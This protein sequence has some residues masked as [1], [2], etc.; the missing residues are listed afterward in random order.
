MNA[1]IT[2]YGAMP[3]P[4]TA[5]ATP[6]RTTDMSQA[7]STSFLMLQCVVPKTLEAGLLEM[8]RRLQSP[9]D[10]ARPETVE[11]LTEARGRRIF[12]SRHSHMVATVVLEVEV[13][14]SA[15]RENDFGQ[16]ALDAL[17]L[18]PEFVGCVDADSGR[19]TDRHCESDIG[20]NA[21]IP[22]RPDV[23]GQEEGR[24]LQRQ[25]GVG[26]PPVEAVVLEFVDHPR[27]ADSSRPH[28]PGCR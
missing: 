16:P 17:L 20:E 1:W 21:Q 23:A 6:N 19:H 7:L 27:R 8:P 11:G 12:R 13:T 3:I 18:V 4:N 26:A 25:I 2:R 14:V 10:A 5:S 22:T 9:A 28:P 15:L 24:V